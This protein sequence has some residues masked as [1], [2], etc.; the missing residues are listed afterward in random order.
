LVL[1]RLNPE[2]HLPTKLTPRFEGPFIVERQYKNDVLCKHVILGTTKE[3]HVTR[4]KLFHG[5]IVEEASEIAMLDQD[6]F[7]IDCILAYRG[8]PLTRTTM[9]FEVKFIDGS[10]LWKPWDKT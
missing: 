5:T 8:N 1:F 7:R 2:G 9:S 3:F 4:L 10:I 6:Q